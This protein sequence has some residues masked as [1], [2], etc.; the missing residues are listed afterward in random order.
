MTNALPG[1]DVAELLADEAIS[2]LLNKVPSIGH[3]E[4]IIKLMRITY[5]DGFLK[6]SQLMSNHYQNFIKE[7][8]CLDP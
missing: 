2:D 7:N 1:F 8:L 5:I 4:K 6:G 3:D